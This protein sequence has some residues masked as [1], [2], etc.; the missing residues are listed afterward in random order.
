MLGV[1][2]RDLTWVVAVPDIAGTLQAALDDW[3]SCL[4]PS[5]GKFDLSGQ[6]CERLG[7]TLSQFVAPASSRLLR[8]PR[9]SD[10]GEPG[11]LEAGAA[12]I[13]CHSA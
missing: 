2:S 3:A 7:I 8:M 10:R 12:F 6:G 5:P 11:R 9:S 1:V 13:F 4:T